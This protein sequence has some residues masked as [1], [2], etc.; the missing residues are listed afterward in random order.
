LERQPVEPGCLLIREERERA[1]SGAPGVAKTFVEVA[2]GDSVVCELGE[3]GARLFSIEL[4]E[5]LDDQ[6]VQL[7]PKRRLE[8]VLERV[9]DQDVCKPLTS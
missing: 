7:G 1:I 9:P 8:A 4:L 5:R 2:C 3:V 6:M